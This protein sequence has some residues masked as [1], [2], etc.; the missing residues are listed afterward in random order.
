MRE[1]SGHTRW[2]LLIGA[3]CLALAVSVPAIALGATLTPVYRF[4]NTK[5]GTHFYTASETEKAN[6]QSTMSATYTFE[7]VAYN[8]ETDN[9]QMNTPLY[10]F[11]NKVTGTHFYT[12][13]ETEK[14]NI[15]ATM[16][17]TFNYE[18]PAY[19]VSSVAAGNTPVYRFYNT[20]TGTHFYTASESEKNNIQATLSG[21][22]TY[23][24]PAFYLAYTPATPP[25]T[26]SP[27]TATD[28]VSIYRGSAVIQFFASDAGSGVDRTFYRLDGAPAVQGSLIFTRTLGAHT[29]EYWSVD[30][31]G[32]EETHHNAAFTL[33]LSHV[34]TNVVECQSCHPGDL[35]TVH[36]SVPAGGPAD[37]PGCEACHASGVTPKFLCSDCHM[38]V[39]DPD[40]HPTLATDHARNTALACAGPDT[41]HNVDVSAIHANTVTGCDVCHG[42]DKTPT[43]NCET[44]GCH[45]GGYAGYHPAEGVAP[46]RVTG[47]CYNAGCHVSTTSNVSDAAMIHASWANPPGC[48]ACH[49]PGVTPTLTC[50]DAA[51]HGAGGA[52]M[53]STHAYAHP[54]AAGDRSEGCTMSYCHGST[55]VLAIAPGHTGC[56]C[57]TYD[58]DH[59]NGIIGAGKDGD[60]A[61]C[62]D[63]H[64]APFDAT[65]GLHGYH[66]TSH[67]AIDPAGAESSVCVS[68][69]GDDVMAVGSRTVAG[70]EV[71]VPADPA[72]PVQEHLGCSCHAHYGLAD[73]T[74]VKSECVECHTGGAAAHGLTNG[75]AA[76]NPNDYIAAGGHNTTA[77]D[78]NG[79]TE[80][81]GVGGV[82]IKD[83]KGATI[84][85]HW[86][87]PTVGV[88][89]SQTVVVNSDGTTATVTSDFTGSLNP[90]DSPVV[91]MGNRTNSAGVT[92]DLSGAI[93][94]DIGWDSVITCYDCHTELDGLVGPQGANAAN[95]G[96]DPNFP[97][98]WTRA[99]L[100]SFDPTGMRSIETKPTSPNKYYQKWG[101]RQWWPANSITTTSEPLIAGDPS[102]MAIIYAGGNY[103]ATSINSSGY[104]S[105][106]VEGAFI[107]QKCHKLVNS[108][109]G[110]AIEGNGSG[111]RSNNLANIGYGNYPHME[112]HG[113][114]VT[115]QGNCVSCHVAIP[116]G[117]KRPRLLVY[118]SDPAPF[119][120]QWVY[121]GYRTKG[122]LDEAGTAND[123][124]ADLGA[125]ITPTDFGYGVQTK[126][127][128]WGF[129]G[130]N[131]TATAAGS[132]YQLLGSTM[133]V[134]GNVANNP[135]NAGTWPV[136]ITA[137]LDGISAGVD[138][139]KEIENPGVDEG[140]EFE[141]T[142]N[143]QQAVIDTGMQVTWSKWAWVEH[144]TFGGVEWHTDNTPG[145]NGYNVDPTLNTQHY[146]NCNGCTSASNNRHTPHN[147]GI[148]PD[149]ANWK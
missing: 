86:P 41:C 106:N 10:R 56:S 97:D 129:L 89:W 127:G 67:D 92:K 63:C 141:A 142:F 48:A 104:S 57:H 113:D 55:D 146:N 132:V 90:T 136:L 96:L 125:A 6:V 51:C 5:A 135:N 116:H 102:T 115:G 84:E 66:I 119:K 37:G 61:E 7:G 12:A 144:G 134:A 133:N 29:V 98:D 99:E 54:S 131:Q 16:A 81:F 147:A 85:Q 68:C 107:C 148:N 112:H 75:D 114:M 15:I 26:T 23:E 2:R 1:G 53:D 88:F 13:S 27:V 78:L 50:F 19:N 34:E 70:G 122:A 24:G 71:T 20:K 87:R 65:P 137:H 59:L 82:V 124:N 21:T 18:G 93:R 22:Y 17:A 139:H 149:V 103:G 110:L 31:A 14:A 52:T 35:M 4:Y 47:Y 36:D 126:Q 145:A 140:R 69:H 64:D 46:H 105:G 138:S 117:W 30:A 11:Y 45:V 77:Y 100:T 33:E 120:T 44:A 73:L 123:R 58:S 8:L 39:T 83:S 108:Y 9:P 128:N 62:M 76:W 43:T 42:V 60:I 91:A 118:G 49:A 130:I 109:Q 3:V 79:G 32:N 143:A 40:T 121:S 25:D 74:T 80:H 94:T 101:S 38:G 111:F 72:A 95:Y 28:L